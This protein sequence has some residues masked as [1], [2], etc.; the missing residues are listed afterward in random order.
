VRP[1]PKRAE[2]VAQVIEHLPRK[3]KVLSSNT[4][5]AK[6]KQMNKYKQINKN[7][8]IIKA[9]KQLEENSPLKFMNF[10]MADFVTVA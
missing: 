6:N 2:G 5:I 9:S 3:C 1:S 4:S 8:E 7:Y 10:S